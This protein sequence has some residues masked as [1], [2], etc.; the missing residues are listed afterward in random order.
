MYLGARSPV[1]LET[2]IELML[3]ASQ[4][5]HLSFLSFLVPYGCPE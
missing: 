3:H 4:L 1:C 2:D 5:S